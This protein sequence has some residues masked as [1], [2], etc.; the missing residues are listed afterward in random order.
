MDN[1]L[2]QSV[3]AVVCVVSLSALYFWLSNAALTALGGDVASWP[4]YVRPWLFA[5]P[6]LLFLSLFLIYPTLQSVFLSLHERMPGRTL[7]FVAFQNY[8]DMLGQPKFTEALR[9]NLFWLV[10]VPALSTALGLVIAQLTDRLRWRTFAQSMIFVPMAI[11]LVGASVIW[12]FVYEFRSIDLSQ[13]GLLNAVVVFFGGQPQTWLFMPFWNNFFLMVVLI[14]I[15][16]GFAMV[17][18]SAAL[19]GVPEDTIEAAII[20]GANPWQVFFRIRLPQVS[21]T[22]IVVWTTITCLVLK[23]FDVVFAMTNGEGGTQVLANYMWSQFT[24]ANDWGI[25]SAA[26][27]VLVLMVMPIMLWNIFGNRQ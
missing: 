26:A 13:I 20:D 14:W 19:R 25:A 3:F 23:I 2:A 22:I 4:T 1:I 21:S 27:I 5:G 7:E 11:S 15:Q 12:K 6:A 16:T 24:R 9:N 18:L 8:R 10:V 17:I